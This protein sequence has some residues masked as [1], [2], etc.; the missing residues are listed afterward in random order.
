MQLKYYV[1]RIKQTFLI[2]ADTVTSWWQP[3]AV[4]RL[5]LRLRPDSI[6]LIWMTWNRCLSRVWRTTHFTICNRRHHV[7]HEYLLAGHCVRNLA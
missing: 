5:T 1:T 3:T 7:C 2:T 4:G 6:W